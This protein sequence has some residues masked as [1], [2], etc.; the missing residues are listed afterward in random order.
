MRKKFVALAEH[1]SILDVVW[2]VSL[3][4]KETEENKC[5][6]T[7]SRPLGHSRKQQATNDNLQ[8]TDTYRPFTRPFIRTTRKALTRRAQLVCDSP[9]S[10]QDRTDFLNNIFSKNNY[11]ADSNRQNTHSNANSK[12]KTNF[13]SGPTSSPGPFPQKWV[14]FEGKALGTRLGNE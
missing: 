10:L 8:K 12:T 2:V 13:N 6:Y 7:F 4:L 11:N 14:F 9:Y 1:L 3:V 5:Y